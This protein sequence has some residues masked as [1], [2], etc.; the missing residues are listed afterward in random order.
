MELNEKININLN[1]S[2]CE[3]KY[4]SFGNFISNTSVE[5]FVTGSNE[6]K[7]KSFLHYFSHDL[8]SSSNN[9]EQNENNSK[10]EKTFLFQTW[11]Y[12]P[13]KIINHIIPIQ[14]NEQSNTNNNIEN[15]K[16]KKSDGALLF[17]SQVEL[18][19]F[20]NGEYNQTNLIDDEIYM[21]PMIE[22]DLIYGIIF[23]LGLKIF[24]IN[25]KETKSLIYPGKKHI[26]NDYINSYE[27]SNIIFVCEDK[28]IYV[29]DKRDEKSFISRRHVMEL[30]LICE[31]SN[32]GKKFYAY[33]DERKS[34]Y[35]YDIRNI[36]QY[37]EIV[38]TDTEIT[39]MIYNKSLN[40]LFFSEFCSQG[41]ICLDSLKQ[42]SIFEVNSDIKDFNFQFGNKIL[43]IISEDNTIDIININ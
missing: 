31:G 19:L 14:F 35:L 36:N 32:D 27:N 21:K 24:D 37:I 39:K 26:I 42:E 9:T 6:S 29:Y 3:L 7:S 22:N 18:L 15:T 5:L 13:S 10:K 30:N 41:I 17:S 40:K 33:S 2:P 11:N 25:K 12:T 4:C 38:K 43:N 28:K 16:M 23:N 8:S 34:L 20:N 1:Y